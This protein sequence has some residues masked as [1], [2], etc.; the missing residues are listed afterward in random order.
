[1]YEYKE[2]K[3]RKKTSIQ[4]VRLKTILFQHC[5]SLVKFCFAADAVEINLHRFL[6]PSHFRISARVTHIS[7]LSIPVYSTLRSSKVLLCSTTPQNVSARTLILEVSSFLLSFFS[8][9]RF[10]LR[11]SETGVRRMRRT[12]RSRPTRALV[13]ILQ[14]A[15][16]RARRSFRLF[17]EYPGEATTNSSPGVACS[18]RSRGGKIGKRI[19]KKRKRIRE[20]L[21]PSSFS[22]NSVRDSI[23]RGCCNATGTHRE[24]IMA[25]L[26][27]RPFAKSI[28]TARARTRHVFSIA[29]AK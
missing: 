24:V 9:V 19:Q 20:K 26:L 6:P 13:K 14:L 22:G 25:S 21:F 12:V 2:E 3:K 15:P 7:D 23:A 5:H 10:F 1:M 16:R 11:T 29:G 17:D 28:K 8:F 27:F 4:R 18:S